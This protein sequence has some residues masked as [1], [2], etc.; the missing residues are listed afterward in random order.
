MLLL[1]FDLVSTFG[2]EIFFFACSFYILRETSN[3]TL[4]GFVIGMMAVVQIVLGPIM[5]NL[6]DYKSNRKMIFIAQLLSVLSITVF[7]VGYQNHLWALVILMMML[8]ATDVPVGLIIE[9]NLAKITGEQLERFVSLRNIVIMATSFLAPV[10]GGI[11]V[12]FLSIEQMGYVIL[13]TESLAM[14]TIAFIPLSRHVEKE[15]QA[16]INN[17]KKGF[18]YIWAKKDLATM[19]VY[20]AVIN[21]IL[22]A[23]PIGIS[24][25]AIQKMHVSSSAFGWIEASLTISMALGSIILAIFPPKQNLRLYLIGSSY[26]IAMIFFALALITMMAMGNLT[27]VLA[28]IGVYI[29][30]GF[31]AQY[32]NIPLQIYFQKRIEE[33]YKA[34]VFSVSFALSQFTKPLSIMFFSFILGYNYTLVFLITGI[35]FVMIVVTFTKIVSKDVFDKGINTSSEEG[36]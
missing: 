10:I 14:L 3:G 26:T 7:L 20:L 30:L 1:I 16:F 19:V 2:S 27:G 6:A 36:V 15:N 12:G 11:V 25:L 35:I 8:T 5:G 21:I 18:H 9:S 29:V 22:Y 31:S 24:M 33:S 34:R 4:Y 28:L 17:F 32:S 13:V 23:I